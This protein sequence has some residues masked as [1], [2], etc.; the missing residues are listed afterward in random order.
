MATVSLDGVNHGASN[1][2]L[3]APSRMDS[4][5][6][7]EH[8]KGD[9]PISIT[10][11][12]TSQA[13]HCTPDTDLAAAAMI[14]WRTDCGMVPVVEPDSSRVVGV[15]TDRDICMAAATKHQPACCVPVGNVMTRDIVTCAHSDSARTVLALMAEHRVR[16]LP[17]VDDEGRLV[18]VLSITDLIRAVGSHGKHAAPV[19][20]GDV[21]SALQSIC[22]P[23]GAADGMAPVTGTRH[24]TSV[25][26]AAGARSA[27]A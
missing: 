15:I 7:S 4:S 18:G 20:P 23:Q 26:A 6:P 19:A 25:S 8:L 10:K 16:R 24:R 21:L 3:S 9:V 12:M 14:M 5:R 13:E 2:S 17:V 1:R 22:R 27:G 11:F